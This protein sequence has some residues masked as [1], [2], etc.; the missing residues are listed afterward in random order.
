MKLT[1]QQQKILDAPVGDILVSAAAGSGKTAVLTDRIVQRISRGET[2]VQHL[3][4]M[5]FTESAAHE[6]KTRIETKL[7]D[8]LSES[9]DMRRRQYL[10]R[11]LSLL[12]G[13]AVSTIHAF[14]LRVIRDFI[15]LLRDASD[16]PLLDASFSVDDGIEAELI[17]GESARAILRDCYER[18]DEW[19]DGSQSSE[20]SSEQDEP[21]WIRPFYRLTD[22]YGSSRTD[23]PLLDLLIAQYQY[24]RS[25]PDYT[26]F[27]HERLSDLA[28]AV[29]DFSSSR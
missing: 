8:A 17:L 16:Q 23:Q 26:S 12:P 21:A 22:S 19:Q 14:C 3:L 13:A 15:Y 6:M 25:L 18:I 28:D 1:S 11:Q 5:T 27:I 24:L 20:I 7:R 2:D 29:L 9:R 10:S 4:V